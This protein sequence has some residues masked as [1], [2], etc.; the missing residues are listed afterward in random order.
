MYLV[1]MTFTSWDDLYLSS[2]DTY[3]RTENRYR[4]VG[5]RL[6]LVTYS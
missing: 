3:A 4:Y 1:R 5:V 2:H 6:C